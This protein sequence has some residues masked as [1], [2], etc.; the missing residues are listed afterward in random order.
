M[1]V[2]ETV[3]GSAVTDSEKDHFIARVSDLYRSYAP[4]ENVTGMKNRLFGNLHSSVD[5]LLDD[6][7]LVA[8]AACSVKTFSTGETCLWRNGIVVDQAYRSRGFYKRLITVALERH[9]TDWTATKTQN[10]RVYETWNSLFAGALLPHPDTELNVSAQK[11][12]SELSGDKSP[13]D[14][15]TFVIRNDYPNDWLVT[16]HRTCRTKWIEEFLAFRL[17]PLDAL[18]LLVKR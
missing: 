18:L 1:I 3:A 16:S 13:V 7:K 10:P 9:A 5:L 17:G 15:R 12:A 11:A 2:H 6:G 4:R 14:P 8:F